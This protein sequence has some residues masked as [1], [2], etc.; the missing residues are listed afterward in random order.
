MKPFR[1]R[2][3]EPAP[4]IFDG[5]F[6]SQLFLRGIQLTNSALAN[7]LHPE[8]VVAIHGDYI[9][10][11]AEV[12]ETNT[13]VASPLHLAMADRDAA[14]A[15]Q[16]V[17]QAVRHARQ[18]V[19]ESGRPVYVAGS[20]GPSPGAIEADAGG[21]D[22]GIANAAVKGAHERVVAAMAEEGVD[23]FCIETMFS[24]KEAAMAA[25]AAR[26]T[27]LPIAVNLTYKY[28]RDRRTGAEVYR[29][30]WGHTAGDLLDI[31]AGGEFSGGVNLLDHIQ[32]LGLNCGAEPE[33]PEHTGMPYAISGV[34]QL[35]E[36]M[37][38]R[39]VV[40][41]R[42]MAYPNAGLPRLDKDRKTTHYPHSPEEMASRAGDLL[43]EGAYLIG[44]CCGTTPAHIR[45][46]RAAV[47][48]AL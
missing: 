46:L 47:A 31:L 2:L 28:T 4:M 6:G 30:D 38:A 48:A 3:Q 23:L 33:R 44:G 41:K 37:A 14:G 25:E 24:A 35:R 36:A 27:G 22:F 29:T 9:A 26:H 39:G 19:A 16:L 34:R 7:E 40:G 42:F 1:Q 18:A 20:L 21:V 12:I 43:A 5:G 45:A 32:I 13:F 8:A 17:R 11:G 10:A 15:E